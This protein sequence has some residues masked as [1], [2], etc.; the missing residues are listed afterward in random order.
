MKRRV[1]GTGVLIVLFLAVAYLLWNCWY[2]STEVVAYKHE[3]LQQVWER[4]EP[5]M[6]PYDLDALGLPP[7]EDLTLDVGE[8]IVLSGWLFDNELD[9]DCGVILHHGRGGARVET[10]MYVPLFWDR[11][12]DLVMFDARHH[13]ESTGEYA[14]YGYYEKEDSLEVLLPLRTIHPSGRS[15]KPPSQ[16]AGRTRPVL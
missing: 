3:T 14:T 2:F 7:P 1:I 11:G 9:G 5:F 13:G 8:G 16:R 10:T 12:C 6:G 15:R 4:T